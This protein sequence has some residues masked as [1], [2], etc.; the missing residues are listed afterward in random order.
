MLRV[1][2]LAV[3]LVGLLAAPALR[4]HQLGRSYCSVHSVPGGLDLTIETATEHL[5][6]VLGLSSPELSQ[7]E[8]DQARDR[9]VRALEERIQARAE[10]GP[11]RV[12]TDPPRL[13]VREGKPS[14]EVTLHFACPA[15]PVTLNTGFRLDLDPTSEIVC[16]IDGAAWV[17]RRGSEQVEIGTPPTLGETLS[18]FVRSGALHV[19]GGIDHVMFVV[20]LLLAAAGARSHGL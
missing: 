10:S 8:L 7:Q 14:V 2:A 1:T 12:E 18:S 11:C 9:L 6:P 4:A 17:F 20:A 13:V 16:A 5:V 15:G 19:Y 3:L